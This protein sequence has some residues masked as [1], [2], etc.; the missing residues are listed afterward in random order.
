MQSR[1]ADRFREVVNKGKKALIPYITAGLPSLDGSLELALRLEDA[2]ADILEI[3]VPFS[4]PIAD[5]PIIQRASEIAL[6]L[7]INTDNVFELSAGIRKK[8]S[9]PIVLMIYYNC[10]FR[11]GIEKFC[12]ACADAGVDGLIVPDL[13]FEESHE[14]TEGIMTLP[15]DLIM[16]AAPSSKGRLKTV[17]RDAKG[18]VYCVSAL[19]VTG[20]RK[21]LFDGLKDLLDDV[22]KVTD[23][24]R[25]VGFGLSSREQIV[26]IKND[27]EGVIIGSSLMRRLMDNGIEDCVGFVSGIRDTL[28]LS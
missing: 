3:G 13:P 9:V 26:K 7:G 19:G 27:C 17:L 21:N 12:N 6:S 15:I 25:A 4:D 5:G 11:Y 1:V 20:E 23:L 14:L 24:P 28:N 2:G 18:F 22:A 10:V 16:L 8:S